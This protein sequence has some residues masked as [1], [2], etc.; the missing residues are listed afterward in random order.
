MSDYP[1]PNEQLPIFNAQEFLIPLNATITLAEANAKYLARTDIATSVAQTTSFTDNI[2]IGNSLL[3]YI[4][5]QGLQIKPT[6]NSEAVFIRTLDGTG[7][8]KQRIECNQ[9]HTHLYD[10]A[11]ITESAT[12]A[13]YTSL[14]QTGTVMDLSNVTTSG[15]MTFQTRTSG[16]APTTPLSLS[17]T[18][19]AIT[20]SQ[21][22][23]GLNGLVCNSALFGRNDTT[24]NIFSG[25][26]G[27]TRHSIGWTI[28]LSKSITSWTSTSAFNVIAQVAP[29][30][31]FTAL[32]NGV[33]KV[34]CCF[35]NTTSLGVSSF[36]VGSWGTP[37]GGT[38]L[39]GTPATVSPYNIGSNLFVETADAAALS[40]F[41]VVMPEATIQ[42]TGN[43]TTNLVLWCYNQYTA[44]P[45]FTFNIWATKIA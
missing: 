45:T 9:T 20:P 1:P 18:S 38:L 27:Y 40:N 36:L 21:T 19:I 37:V 6:V 22:A 5:A 24:A 25:T 32:S 41:G 14:Q 35:N 7:A 31:E 33:W 26:L 30:T 34:G 13:N 39:N 23:T 11:R 10:Q 2:T 42:F 43:G 28:K 44:Q 8:T 17:S 15:T 29:S 16:G 4:P 3:D 12:P